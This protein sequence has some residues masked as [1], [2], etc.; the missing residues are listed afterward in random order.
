MRR[1]WMLRKI[2]QMI[3]ILISISRIQWNSLTGVGDMRLHLNLLNWWGRFFFLLF[4]HLIC[5]R[6]TRHDTSQ[7]I[8]KHAQ[9]TFNK[10]NYL[11]PPNTRANSAK[12]HNT[13]LL[14]D[15]N[16]RVFF[17]FSLVTPALRRLL[18]RS[19]KWW[20]RLINICQ[21]SEKQMDMM[22]SRIFCDLLKY[23]QWNNEFTLNYY[24]FLHQTLLFLYNL[25]FSR[26]NEKSQ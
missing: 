2:K 6:T 1:I 10:R 20:F 25:H 24:V 8:F 4:L 17:L 15:V 9:L 3:S 23:Q 5:M 16:Y 12:C 26:D 18:R 11:H 22:A 7:L 14:C 21:R 13:T 19:L